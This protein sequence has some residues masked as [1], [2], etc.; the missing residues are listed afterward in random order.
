MRLL[1]AIALVCG[2]RPMTPEQPQVHYGTYQLFLMARPGGNE[3]VPS[4]FTRGAELF[5]QARVQY[6]RGEYLQAA[7][8]FMS[9]AEAMRIEQDQ[10]YWETAR[11]DRLWSYRNA[12]YAW[13]MANALDQARPALEAAAT[14]DP[15]CAAELQQLAQKLPHAVTK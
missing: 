12:A 14:A 1:I 5:E 9:A 7:A 10:P 15:L 13:A 4:E 8:N 6:E 3:L 11:T 2:C